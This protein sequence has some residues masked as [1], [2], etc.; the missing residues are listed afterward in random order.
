MGLLIRRE[1]LPRLPAYG[2]RGSA[3]L[4]L[5]CALIGGC[6]WLG[7][8]RNS[9]L[10]TDIES[11]GGATTRV[12]PTWLQSKTGPDKPNV[13]AVVTGSGCPGD[14]M[15]VLRGVSR[16]LDMTHPV[17]TPNEAIPVV[18]RPNAPPAIRF[19]ECRLRT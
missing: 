4:T 12:H 11:T 10:S 6:N 16:S 2:W 5:T 9:D 1:P 15:L 14:E 7:D 18:V 19:Q 13:S 17:G 3:V 8:L